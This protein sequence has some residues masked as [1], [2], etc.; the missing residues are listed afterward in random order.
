MWIGALLC[1]I[2]LTGIVVVGG[3]LLYHGLR[4]RLP[5]APSSR[6]SLEQMLSHVDSIETKSI[7]DLGSGTGE[8]LLLVAEKGGKAIGIEINPF[9][10]WISRVRVWYRGY[11]GRVSV[12]RGDMFTIPLL[13]VD[14]VT[15][16][17]LS[18]PTARLA[19][20][21][22]AELPSHC[23]VISH[24]FPLPNW[25]PLFDSDEVKVYKVSDQNTTP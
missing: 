9:L 8:V 2:G 1:I 11:S 19:P 15:L 5:Y 7:L 17:T 25:A 16:Y 4:Y 14:V 6:R 20:R 12:V 18:N 24:A 10:V 22:R 21:L 23:L 13:S 3:S